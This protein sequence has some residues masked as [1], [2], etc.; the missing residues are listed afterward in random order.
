MVPLTN[1]LIRWS[2]PDVRSWVERDM[3]LE[4]GTKL[5]YAAYF[6]AGTAHTPLGITKIPGVTRN[7]AL[8]ATTPT[9]AQI[10][11][12]ARTAEL[13]MEG[14]NLPMTNAAWVM[15][16]RTRTYLADLRDGNGNRYFPEL[17]NALPMWRGRPVMSTTQISIVGG[18]TTD[19]T[20]ILLVNFDDVYFGE[21][22]GISFSVSTEATYVKNGVTISA[23]QND[24]TLIKASLEADVDM[25][26]LEAVSVI[27][28]VR[29]GA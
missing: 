6:G 25:R 9:I 22:A 16:P 5:D 4:M 18:G 23:F 13:A 21:G 1:Q 11:T 26:Y 2:L 24:L 29:W 7:A 28:G 20:E 8:G 3:S 10:E 19:E 17:Q 12:G 15:A 27:T 14:R